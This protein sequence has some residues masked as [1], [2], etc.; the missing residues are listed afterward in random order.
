MKLPVKV[1]N[2]TY[3]LNEKEEKKMTQEEKDELFDELNAL[4]V[5]RGY[6]VGNSEI[7][8]FLREFA[9]YYDD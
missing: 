8:N 5:T 7:A 4:L 2:K 9:D 1:G 3:Y 6:Y